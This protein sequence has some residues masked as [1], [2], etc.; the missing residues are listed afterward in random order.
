MIFTRACPKGQ[1]LCCSGFANS[2][3]LVLVIVCLVY[4]MLRWAGQYSLR[5]R[6]AGGKPRQRIRLKTIIQDIVY[7][8]AKPVNHAGKW[9][10]K[11]RSDLPH[12][13]VFRGLAAHFAT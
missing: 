11:I 1:A 6:V 2:N 3:R 7:M 9:V 10:L 12:L 4:N 5:Y 8:A 13:E